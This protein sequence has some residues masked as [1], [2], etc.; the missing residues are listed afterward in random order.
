MDILLSEKNKTMGHFEEYL[1]WRKEQKG[2]RKSQGKQRSPRAV[3]G[4]SMELVSEHSQPLIPANPK[5]LKDLKIPEEFTKL[6]TE[7]FLKFDGWHEDERI[8]IFTTERCLDFMENNPNWGA[9]ATFDPTPLL[10]SQLWIIFVRLGHTYVPMVF[11]LMTHR[12]SGSYSFVLQKLNKLRLNLAPTMNVC[13]KGGK[14][15]Y[16][17]SAEFRREVNCIVAL[18]F[19]PVVDVEEAFVELREHFEAS[20]NATHLE[21]ILDYFE[22]TQDTHTWM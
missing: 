21:I 7:V 13:E 2:S 10:F 9:D 15:L 4:E 22:D 14:R 11:V 20:D 3:I 19:V 5:S 18:A 1:Y 17:E 6:G 12:K 16:D 8:M